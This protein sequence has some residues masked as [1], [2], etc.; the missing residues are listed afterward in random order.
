MPQFN[1]CTLFFLIS[2]A[3]K[4]VVVNYDKGYCKLWLLKYNWV[5]GESENWETR[6][7]S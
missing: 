1:S 7:C 4:S 6:F 5:M 3:V 2:S